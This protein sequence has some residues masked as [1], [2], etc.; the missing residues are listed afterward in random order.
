MP[1][2][3]S[4]YQDNQPMIFEIKCHDFEVLFGDK[5]HN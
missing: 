2:V 3:G 5:F 4:L 1:T